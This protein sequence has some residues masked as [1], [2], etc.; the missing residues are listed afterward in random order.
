VTPL[1]HPLAVP[2]QAHS[3][4]SPRLVYAHVAPLSGADDDPDAI[5]FPLPD[6]EPGEGRVTFE[7]LDAVRVCRGEHMPYPYAVPFAGGDWVYEISD[8]SWLLER[9]T[10]EFEHYKT[11]LIGSYRHYLFSFHD[12]YIEAI[13][14][15]IW[16]DRPEPAS[17]PVPAPDHPLARLDRHPPREIQQSASGIVWELRCSPRDDAALLEGSKLCS[18]RLYQFNLVFDGQSRESASVWLRTVDG[19]TTSRMD[20]T[21][22][23]AVGS[24]DGLAALEDFLVCWEGHV[25]TVAARRRAM[26]KPVG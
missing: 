22:A 4:L 7:S 14:E 5:Y 25:A 18:Q 17:C 15:G 21:W 12:E 9:H 23:G 26:G 6:S 24:R 19:R 3:V 8:S 13:A 10:Y 1:A 16:L 11:P 20:R 2:L